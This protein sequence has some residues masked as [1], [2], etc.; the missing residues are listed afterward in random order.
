MIKVPIKLLQLS[1]IFFLLWLSIAIKPAQ[2]KTLTVVSDEWCPYICDDRVLPGFLV[3]IVNE[4]ARDNDLK[5]KFTLMPLARA[6]NLAKKGRVD[7]LLALTSQ[8]IAELQLQQSQLSFGGL[9]NDFY[10]RAI[11]PWRFQSIAHLSASLKDNVILGTIN[12][13]H[14]GE[15]LNQLLKSNTDHVF[16]ASGNSPLEK[17]LKMLQMGRLDIL[18][19]SRLTVQYQ[20]SKLPKSSIIYAG[21]QGE[22]TP[23][24]LGFSSLLSKEK[25]QLFDNGLMTLRQSGKLDDILAKYALTDW[26]QQ[27]P[28]SSRNISLNRQPPL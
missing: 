7:I 10:V 18:L 14:Y 17:Q 11:N 27:A 24:F 20:L 13:Y 1:L 25:V 9:Y 19:D 22:F 6:L 28:T 8:H 4:I 23:L 16:P 26:Q 15:Q 3:E 21:S 5:V 2:A 12:G